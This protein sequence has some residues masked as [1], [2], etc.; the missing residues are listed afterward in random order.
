MVAAVPTLQT[1][2]GTAAGP[3]A[4]D[5]KLWRHLLG[6]R[7]D[8]SLWGLLF[9]DLGCRN[10]ESLHWSVEAST[11]SHRDSYATTKRK[12][13]LF[14]AWHRVPT[15][16]QTWG[17]LQTAVHAGTQELFL[18]L[19]FVGLAYRI[20]DVFAASYYDCDRG[21]GDG[22]SGSGRRLVGGSCS[23]QKQGCI[24]LPLGLLHSMAPFV[25][26]VMLWQVET[27]HRAK[28]A[29]PPLDSYTTPRTTCH[30]PLPATC[31]LP[32]AT[33]H[34]PPTTKGTW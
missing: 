22:G 31:H 24:G 4:A 11:C 7:H 34:R 19:I 3:R 26:M 25:C 27:A 2:K 5:C 10:A 30:L 15:V 23:S 8:R 21:D 14:Y 13:T 33:C 28:Y 9:P 18:D 12:S 1:E 17:E 16:R 20:G 32:P 6:L 29:H